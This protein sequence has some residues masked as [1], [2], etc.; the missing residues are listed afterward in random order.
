VQ[1]NQD[2]GVRGASL[3]PEAANLKLPKSSLPRRPLQI[4]PAQQVYVQVKNGLPR[5]RPDVEHG[6][7]AILDAALACDVGGG[8]LAVA[9]KLGIL[10]QRFFQSADVLLGN[11]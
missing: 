1:L 4:S 11:Y 3:Q 2:L 9:D 8:E 5:T 7:V 10:G 6:S